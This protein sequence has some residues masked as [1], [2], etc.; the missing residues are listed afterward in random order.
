MSTPSKWEVLST[1]VPELTDDQQLH[2]YIH[3]LKQHICDELELHNVST[4]EEAQRKARIT[5][6][7]SRNMF[8]HILTKM[9]PKG[10]ISN[11]HTQEI[12]YI[13]HHNS[14]KEQRL[15]YPENKGR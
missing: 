3:N 13:H 14:G 11:Q 15:V 5:E 8:I 2:T 10:S 12:K 9:T 1:R 6:K 7:N 4:L